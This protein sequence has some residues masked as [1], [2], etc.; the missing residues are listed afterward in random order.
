MA[1][2]DLYGSPK[3]VI[4]T[5]ILALV[6]AMGLFGCGP[7]PPRL[8]L[9]TL[10]GPTACPG[11]TV[12]VPFVIRIDPSAAEQVVA[13]DSQ[14]KRYEVWWSEGFVA[15]DAN[16]PVVRDPRGAIVA[17]DGEQVAGAT[18]HSYAIC[19]GNDSVYILIES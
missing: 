2:L 19:G 15:G 10:E 7:E 6:G 16:D 14:G 8:E 11:A 1:D 13:I 9:N 12:P 5:L 17:R 18:L 4:R 3:P